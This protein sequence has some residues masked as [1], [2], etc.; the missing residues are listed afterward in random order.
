MA[1]SAPAFLTGGPDRP[2]PAITPEPAIITV[3]MRY[4]AAA[5]SAAG[6]ETDQFALRSPATVS[7][8][9]TAS[10]VRRGDRLAAVL[11]RCS[12]LLG[13]IAVHSGGSLVTD[14]DVID[15]LPPF[16]GG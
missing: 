16:A 3:T 7:D 5:K 9:L 11:L 14:G 12:Y 15:V 1:E 10:L 4:F 8:V 13:E 2:E 6:V